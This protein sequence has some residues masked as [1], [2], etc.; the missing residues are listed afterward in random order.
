M[1]YN[2]EYPYTDPERANSDWL[3]QMAKEVL[4]KVDEFDTWK[5]EHQKEYDELK[6]LYDGIVKGDFPESMELALIS[7]VN[8]HAF[9]LMSEQIKNVFFGLTDDGYFVAYMPQSWD[10]ITF[11]TTDLDINIPN[12][13]YGH[14]VLSY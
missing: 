13:E 9:D 8:R 4:S 6:K 11:N 10:D 5:N 14:L 12:I 3:L 7:W 2:Y 1:A